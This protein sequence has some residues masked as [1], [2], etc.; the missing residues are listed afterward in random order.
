MNRS[1]SRSRGAPGCG[2]VT[3]CT[4]SGGSSPPQRS[5]ISGTS[6]TPQNQDAS[7]LARSGSRIWSRN[8]AV[9]HEPPV[10]DVLLPLGRDLPGEV[11]RGQDHVH[12][13]V[14]TGRGQRL[15]RSA[16]MGAGGVAEDL[17]ADDRGA[18]PA[19]HRL[20]QPVPGAAGLLLEP[21]PGELHQVEGGQELGV[22]PVGR[23]A[24]PLSGE[25]LR[26]VEEPV[27]EERGA[28]LRSTDVQDHAVG[29]GGPPSSD[30][31]TSSASA[32]V[33]AG[34]TERASP[35]SVEGTT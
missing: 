12:L 21:A 10:L 29:H 27:L 17:V 30:V 23:V 2:T 13:G 16:H 3:T 9:R 8:S 1:Q 4:C 26:V 33:S 11:A 31:S 18:G 34:G 7:V 35:A 5:R 28:G 24:D 25:D 6:W 14:A 19:A 20:G 22:G 32:R 15:Q